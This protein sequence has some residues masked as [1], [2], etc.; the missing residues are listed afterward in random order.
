MPTLQASLTQPA[1]KTLLGD[2]DD[3]ANDVLPAIN[4]LLAEEEDESPFRYRVYIPLVLRNY[5]W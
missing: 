2:E 4:L 1:I 3:A 5:K